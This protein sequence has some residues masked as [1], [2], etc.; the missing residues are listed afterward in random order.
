MNVLYT[1]KIESN[2][3]LT[4]III[5]KGFNISM[6]NRRVDILK[7]DKLIAITIW[8]KNMFWLNLNINSMNIIN[9]SLIDDN[10]KLWYY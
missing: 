3:L 10:L 4:T 5:D 9:N 6:K 7:D 8:D 2:L 1:P